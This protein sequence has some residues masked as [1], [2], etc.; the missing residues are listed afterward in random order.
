MLTNQTTSLFWCH[1]SSYQRENYQ[2]KFEEILLNR[3]NSDA[4]NNIKKTYFN[5]YTSIA[6]SKDGLATLYLVLNK[7]ILYKN[8]LL[9]QDD[10]TRLAQNLSLFNHPKAIEVLDQAEK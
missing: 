7:D 6:Y 3:L 9:N 8:L 10:Y 5:A 2:T 1:L 4:S